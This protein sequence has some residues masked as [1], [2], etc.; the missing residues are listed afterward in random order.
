M[1][2]VVYEGWRPRNA[3]A[4]AACMFVV[5]CYA[6]QE[7]LRYRV[8]SAMLAAFAGDDA[9]PTAEAIAART[10]KAEVTG[11]TWSFSRSGRFCRGQGTVTNT[12]PEPLDGFYLTVQL[13]DASGAV[14][15][16]GTGVPDLKPLPAYAST[17]FSFMEACPP[18]T[19]S[20]S[21]SATHNYGDPVDLV[22]KPL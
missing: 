21:L 4:L 19:R 12:G 13:S 15:A 7:Y 6:G 16:S 10:G 1:A 14:V 17:P 9:P 5:G 2:E 11:F 8:A 20:A 18:S 3:I 22:V